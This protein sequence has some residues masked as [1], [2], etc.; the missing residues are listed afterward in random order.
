M[1]DQEI[2][3]KIRRRCGWL[4]NLG[5]SAFLVYVTFFDWCLSKTKADVA[6]GPDNISKLPWV[7]GQSNAEM[8]TGLVLIAIFM[9]GLSIVISQTWNRLVGRFLKV[10]DM[11]L[12]EA[13]AIVLWVL[14]IAIW[15]H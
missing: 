10:D 9:A 2:Q 15:E 14:L 1:V 12:G 3:A 5:F 4:F 13:Y 8:V 6:A 11:S 7:H